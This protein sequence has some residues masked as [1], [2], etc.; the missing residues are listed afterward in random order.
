M[1]AEWLQRGQG[2]AAAQAAAKAAIQAM[3]NEV[4]EKGAGRSVAGSSAGHG[5]PH[6]SL[7]QRRD[8]S[9]QSLKKRDSSDTSRSRDTGG[10]AAAAADGITSPMGTLDTAVVGTSGVDAAPLYM[11]HIDE[12]DGK[13]KVANNMAAGRR[14]LDSWHSPDA[15]A[16]GIIMWEV[17]TTRKPW[18]GRKKAKFWIDVMKGMRPEVLPHEAEAAPSGYV[19]LMKKMWAH[20]ASKRPVFTAALA[21]LTRIERDYSAKHPRSTMKRRRSRGGRDSRAPGT[22]KVRGSLK[23][24]GGE[25]HTERTRGKYDKPRKPLQPPAEEGTD[26]LPAGWRATKS[27]SRPGKTVFENKF[28]KERIDFKPT[29]VASKVRGRSA[30][31]RAPPGGRSFS[32]RRGGGPRGGRGKGK[33]GKGDGE[34][35]TMKASA[36]PPLA[37]GRKKE[38]TV[39]DWAKSNQPSLVSGVNNAI[40]QFARKTRARRT[41][42]GVERSET[43]TAT[44]L[45][46]T[47]LGNTLLEH[48]AV[49]GA[50][51]GGAPARKR[52]D[53]DKTESTLGE[54]TVLQHP[55]LAANVSKMVR[56][57]NAAHTRKSSKDSTDTNLGKGDE[58]SS[59]DDDDDDDT[60]SEEE[61]SS[62]DQDGATI[63]NAPA[64][65]KQKLIDRL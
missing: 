33:G 13:V 19:R 8:S 14:K 17:C 28:T 7:K 59:D 55:N 18:A 53:G 56:A 42:R 63:Q 15:Y 43:A 25:S 50:G 32:G 41:A 12:N 31:I 29:R 65:A 5:S 47:D 34:E 58:S 1:I 26:V 21:K 9:S 6:V 61:S 52:S 30:D 51:G 40:D 2:G 39:G 11:A 3:H 60:S 64:G 46:N 36:E 4:V 23:F 16:F 57:A 20:E 22:E 54:D 10:G 37:P 38:I 35:G 44:D 48:P 45:G 27:R 62:D 49:G 24:G